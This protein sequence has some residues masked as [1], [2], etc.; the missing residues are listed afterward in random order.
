MT[1][2]QKPPSTSADEEQRETVPPR[3]ML[4]D[5]RS[6]AVLS[7]AAATTVLGLLVAV[8]GVGWA[9]ASLLSQVSSGLGTVGSVTVTVLLALVLTFFCLKDGDRFSRWLLRWTTG[10]DQDRHGGSR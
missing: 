4:G 8:S 1:D 2:E 9:A 3:A 6:G 5:I 7:A 10:I